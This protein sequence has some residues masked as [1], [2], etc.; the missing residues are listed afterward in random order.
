[1]AND[2]TATAIG[3]AF[4][5]GY[6]GHYFLYILSMFNIKG[7]DEDRMVQRGSKMHL[8]GAAA[9]ISMKYDWAYAA[10]FAWFSLIA[11]IFY[12]VPVWV[13][14]EETRK[15]LERPSYFVYNTLMCAWWVGQVIY[16]TAKF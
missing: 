15:K 5:L 4:F 10:V 3:V 11:L 14:S 6:L 16:V 8:F 13:S 12:H 2:A 1:M 9:I 7:I